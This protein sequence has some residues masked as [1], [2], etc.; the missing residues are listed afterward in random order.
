M[1]IADKDMSAESNTTRNRTT[2]FWRTYE[3]PGYRES[4]KS[5]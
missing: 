5:L 3:N 1:E 2:D 4:T